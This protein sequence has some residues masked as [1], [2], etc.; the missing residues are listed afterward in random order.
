MDQLALRE[1]MRPFTEAVTTTLRDHPAFAGAW[2]SWDPVIFHVAMTE[3]GVD[4]AVTIISQSKYSSVMEVHSVEH[5]IDHLEGVLRDLVGLRE[6][7]EKGP[8]FDAMIDVG[9]NAVQVITKDATELMQLMQYHSPE[10]ASQVQFIEEPPA[11]PATF[12]GLILG[13]ACSAAFMIKSLSNSYFG[14]LSAGHV[15]CPS[16]TTYGSGLHTDGQLASVYGRRD[17]SFHRI[18]NGGSVSNEIAV[19]VSPY[20]RSI[21]STIDWGY[22]NGD[23]VCKN[24]ESTGY[25]CGTITSIYFSPNWVP[26]GNRFIVFN[27]GCSG[28]D[29]GAPVFAY[30]TAYGVLAGCSSTATIFGSISYAIPSGYYVYT[31]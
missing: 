12:G 14:P 30:N 23:Q 7:S 16:D 5:T 24:G 25:K 21:T 22:T 13:N 9:S 26:D 19:N 20:Y 2:I 15:S 17:S 11:Q 27:T 3:E 28:G 29:S 10:Y 1:D 6:I 31:Y 4:E 8:P 18:T